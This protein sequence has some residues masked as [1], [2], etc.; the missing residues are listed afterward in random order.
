MLPR[1]LIKRLQSPPD[2]AARPRRTPRHGPGRPL[3]QQAAA[4]SGQRPA[5]HRRQQE[6]AAGRQLPAQQ[7]QR[8]VLRL[9]PGAPGRLHLPRPG[10]R[11]PAAGVSVAPGVALAEPA[12][13]PDDPAAR[14]AGPGPR[15]RAGPLP[16]SRRRRQRDESADA[17]PAP[18]AALRAPRRARRPLSESR[19]PREA[20]LREAKAGREARAEGESESESE[21]SEGR[22]SSL[23]ASE[24]SRR[25]AGSAGARPRPKSAARAPRPGRGLTRSNRG[26]GR[27]RP[28][29]AWP[30][31][32]L[33]RLSP[34]PA[35]GARMQ[36]DRDQPCL[37]ARPR[38]SCTEAA[39]QAPPRGGPRGSRRESPTRRPRG[40]EPDALKPGPGRAG[41]PEA[42]PGPTTPWDSSPR[43]VRAGSSRT[44]RRLRERPW[45]SAAPTIPL[46]PAP[47]WAARFASPV[48]CVFQRERE[49]E[50]E[51]E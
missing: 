42:W 43:A 33:G 28:C 27:P 2:V 37:P 12:G 30:S 50:R 11:G 22:R 45:H 14:R 15:A 3:A 41:L 47:P 39:V 8:V 36:V 10:P 26:P 48:P 51:R 16:L 44:H 17:S 7:R 34:F 49:R 24:R 25:F 31:R 35:P 46:R 19:C 9:P 38:I 13:P 32:G 4:Q 21:D 18:A 1:L 5:A 6:G 23:R 29:T 40:L 20:A